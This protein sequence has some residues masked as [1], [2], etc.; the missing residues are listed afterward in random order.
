TGLAVRAGRNCTTSTVSASY[1]RQSRFSG[2]LYSY[3]FTNATVTVKSI[4]ATADGGSDAG[5]ASYTVALPY[6]PSAPSGSSLMAHGRIRP[7]GGF[8]SKSKDFFYMVGLT[9]LSTSS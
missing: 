7:F 6:N 3:D 1:E 4:L 2:T 9:A 8:C 5:F